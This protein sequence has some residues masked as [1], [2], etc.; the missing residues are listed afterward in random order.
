MSPVGHKQT[1]HWSFLL[2]ILLH[3]ADIKTLYI[4]FRHLI[5]QLCEHGATLAP[6]LIT[7]NPYTKLRATNW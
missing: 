2:R 1:S 5:R 3:D 7:A 4:N 6:N